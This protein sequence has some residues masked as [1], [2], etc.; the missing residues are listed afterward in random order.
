MTVNATGTYNCMWAV[1]PQMRE[2]K[3]GLIVNISSIAGKRA[4]GRS[5]AWPTTPRSSP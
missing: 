5:A 3:D 1:L 4:P 2:R